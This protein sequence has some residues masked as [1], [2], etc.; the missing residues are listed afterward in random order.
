MFSSPNSSSR[1]NSSLGAALEGAELIA[2]PSLSCTELISFRQ[3]ALVWSCIPIMNESN[4]EGQSLFA[5]DDW[6]LLSPLSQI[7]RCCCMML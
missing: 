6:E 1:S 5:A 3:F 7:H 2:A 4:S